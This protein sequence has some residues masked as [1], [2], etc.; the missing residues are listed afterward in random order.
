[1]SVMSIYS[2]PEVL[3]SKLHTTNVFMSEKN[4]VIS[5]KPAVMERK[6]SKLRGMFSDGRLSVEKHLKMMREDKEMFEND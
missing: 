5:L 2:L 3:F 1:M 6:T 4:G